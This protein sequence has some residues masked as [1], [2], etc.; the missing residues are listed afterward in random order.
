MMAGHWSGS[1]PWTPGKRLVVGGTQAGTAEVRRT[2]GKEFD[3]GKSW[4]EISKSSGVG[5]ISAEALFESA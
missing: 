1:C 2:E 3:L 4:K 5:I